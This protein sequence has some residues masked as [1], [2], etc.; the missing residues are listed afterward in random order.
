MN[1]EKKPRLGA[2]RYAIRGIAAVVR[3]E[4]NARIHVFAAI[5]VVVFGLALDLD[6]GDWIAVCIAISLVWSAECFNT[7]IEALCDA[8]TLEHD[9]RIERAKDV[10]AGSVLIAAIGAVAVGL[11]VFGP[12]LLALFQA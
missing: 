5:V 8:V 1:S 4:P 11:F 10:A 2:F 7:A 3:S 6:R 9:P 12:R